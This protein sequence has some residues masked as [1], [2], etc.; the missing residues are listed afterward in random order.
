MEAALKAKKPVVLLVG[1]AAKG[2]MFY[3]V[4][5]KDNG[6]GM[7]HENIPNMLGRVLSGSKYGFG[8]ERR[9]GTSREDAASAAIPG[10]GAYRTTSSV[11]FQHSSSH[12]TQ[13]AF[14]FGSSNREHAAKLY[15]SNAMSRGSGYSPG[16]CYSLTSSVG[17]QPSTRGRT[18]PGWAFL[19]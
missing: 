12:Q 6:C 7:K 2:D 3:R 4:V 14:G 18:A 11:G 16:P 1:K 9:L 19:F 10:P 8:T 5:V 13:P 15:V 17:A